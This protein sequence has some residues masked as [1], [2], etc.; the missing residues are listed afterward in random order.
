LLAVLA[1]LAVAAPSI[2]NF[3]ANIS[4]ASHSGQEQDDS[5]SS[6]SSGTPSQTGSSVSS[7]ITAS[8]SPFYIASYLTRLQDSGPLNDKADCYRCTTSIR[9]LHPSISDSHLVQHLR[10]CYRCLSSPQ[11]FEEK[12]Q[13]KFAAAQL[14]FFYHGLPWLNLNPG[15]PESNKSRPDLPVLCSLPKCELWI[16]DN[17]V[18]GP[19]MHKPE[20]STAG[21]Q[22]CFACQR[23]AALGALTPA[24]ARSM[25]A[26]LARMIVETAGQP[27]H[28][29]HNSY[30]SDSPDLASSPA[31]TQACF[32]CIVGLHSKQV[33]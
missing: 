1:V 7:D 13:A 3:A 9:L 12:Q 19:R 31:A 6:K 27:P 22:A 26:E 32:L 18:L 4:G 11:T 2:K 23:D 24:E 14:V 30:S 29:S 28:P 17:P 16:E 15:K 8:P 5:I 33:S 25:R 10:S 21:L 20:F